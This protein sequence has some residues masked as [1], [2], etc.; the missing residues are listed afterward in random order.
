MSIPAQVARFTFG[1]NADNGETWNTSFWAQPLSDITS[2][3]EFQAQVD[4]LADV[5]TGGTGF[6]T[7]M[8]PFWSDATHLTFF[9]GLYYSNEQT[10]SF[11]GKHAYESPVVGTGT[12]PLPLQTCA[13]LSLE[14]A[15]PTRRGKGR[16]YLPANAAAMQSGHR[17]SDTPVQNLV[18]AAA[19]FFSILDTGTPGWTPGVMSSAGSAFRPLTA[20]HMDNKPDIQ[21]RR[22]NDMSSGTIHR[23]VIPSG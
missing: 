6:V 14:T 10:A 3:E 22:A 5:L 8:R 2:Q 16:M 7:Q 19:D 13:V 4:D 11:I 23:A 18:N 1:G 9:D 12:T 15:V 17:F 20:V 21:R